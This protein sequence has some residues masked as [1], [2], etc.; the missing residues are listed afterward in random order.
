MTPPTSISIIVASA[1]AGA[2]PSNSSRRSIGSHPACSSTTS[3]PAPGGKERALDANE[4]AAPRSSIRRIDRVV[5][6][7]IVIQHTFRRR[8]RIL[9]HL[10]NAVVVAVAAHQ[11]QRNANQKNEAGYSGFSCRPLCS[12]TN[13]PACGAPLPMGTERADDVEG[14]K[15][16]PV[17]RSI[18][19]TDGAVPCNEG[20]GDGRRNGAYSVFMRWHKRMTPAA[21]V[22]H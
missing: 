13:G 8:Y 20:S 17:R 12:R 1:P 3:P 15:I 11:G 10:G 19:E 14:V 9:Y 16:D 4:G 5:A 6:R 2:P 18:R 22:R 7:L 21:F